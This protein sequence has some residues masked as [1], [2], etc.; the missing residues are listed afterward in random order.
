MESRVIFRDYQEQQAQDHNDLQEYVKRSFDHVVF[1]AVTAER[2]FGGF[3]ITKTGQTEIQ[4]APGR[5][6]DV[7]G[8]VYALNTTTSQS[9]VSYLASTYKR[10]VL[11]TALG[12]DIETDVEERDYLTRCHNRSLGT[13]V[14]LDYRCPRRCDCAYAGNRSGRSDHPGCS[15]RTRCH[16][17]CPPR[18]YADCL[19]GYG[20]G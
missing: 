15:H 16:R 3:T 9:M 12:T 5:F 1:D 18:S 13:A 17:L 10:W 2:R 19:R 11:I 8:V 6:F 7:L 14:Y 4:I 20:G